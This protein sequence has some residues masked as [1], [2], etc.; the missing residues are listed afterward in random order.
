[1]DGGTETVA[2]R[3][4]P[5]IIL[6]G[7]ARVVEADVRHRSVVREGCLIVPHEGVNRHAVERGA[8]VVGGIRV[9]AGEA[10]IPEA[11]AGGQ[12]LPEPD[13]RIDRRVHDVTVRRAVVPVENDGLLVRRHRLHKTH[14]GRGV[15]Q[16]VIAQ[17]GAIFRDEAHRNEEI[18]VVARAIKIDAGPDRATG[19]EQ[20]A[21]HLGGVGPV[22][23]ERFYR[24]A[25]AGDMAVGLACFPVH[26]AIQ[27]TGRG[28]RRIRQRRLGC[29]LESVA[30]P[31]TMADAGD[32]DTVVPDAI[33]RIMLEQM[34]D[35]MLRVLIAMV[36]GVA[37]GVKSR[38]G[39]I[40]HQRL[41]ICPDTEPIG[42]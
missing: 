19:F 3:R 28:F 41:S 1:M 30:T 18:K 7:G 35:E 13:L 25:H 8:P 9:H 20:A 27:F 10:A 6:P 15:V 22:L 31:R 39:V 2:L 34:A 32:R 36:T 37:A 26:I 16:L 23:A 12:R 17:L 21:E 11:P 5:A 24:G 42:M 14:E 4:G 29:R 38:P 40:Q 33:D